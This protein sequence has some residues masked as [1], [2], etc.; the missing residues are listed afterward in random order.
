MQYCTTVTWKHYSSVFPDIKTIFMIFATQKGLFVSK[1]YPY[2]SP[3]QSRILCHT[4]S[5]VCNA[6]KW[7][8][9]TYTAFSS[10]VGFL[11]GICHILNPIT[12]MVLEERILPVN[13]GFLW[14]R[15]PV[16]KHH[17][18]LLPVLFTQEHEESPVSGTG[19]KPLPF[20]I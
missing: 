8:R 19:N 2:C 20:F 1:N 4:Y 6:S 10:K 9:I 16:F 11:H 12:T 15:P 7:I 3:T 14:V 17:F 13:V 5:T 18:S